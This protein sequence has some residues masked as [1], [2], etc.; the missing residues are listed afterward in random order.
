MRWLTVWACLWVSGAAAHEWY[1]PACCSV[2]DCAPVAADVVRATDEG[3]LVE[4]LPGQHPYVSRPI[5]LV[6]PYGSHKVRSSQ[7]DQFHLCVGRSQN[8]FCVY[9]PMFGA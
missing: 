8:I 3:W 4:V 6:I 5:R 2:D 7:D 1:D 9:V